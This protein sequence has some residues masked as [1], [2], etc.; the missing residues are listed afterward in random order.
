MGRQD[1]ARA[2]Q[3]MAQLERSSR[4]LA[5]ARQ[6]LADDATEA[7]AAQVRLQIICI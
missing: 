6:A 3:L 5:E 4:A 2:K 1:E 7:R